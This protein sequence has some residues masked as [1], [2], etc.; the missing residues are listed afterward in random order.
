MG[1]KNAA[2]QFQMMIDDRLEPV[3]DVAD[4]YIDD[5]IVGTRVELGEDLFAAHD[6]DLR[7][8]LQLLK[9]EQLV[10]DIGKCKFFVPEVEFCGHIL[11]NGTRRPAP[12]KLS[13]IEK[14]EVPKVITELRAFLGFTNYY[15]SYVKG[16]ADVVA[17]LQDKLKVPKEEGKKG[18]KKQITWTPTDQEAFEEIK[19]RMCSQ[20][21][22][23][24][25][26]PDKP[27]VLRVDA[28]GYAVGAVLE[29]LVE[30]TRRPT[31]E[32][33]LQKRTVPMA[34]MSQKLAQSQRNWVAR[35]QETY[36]IIL[37]LQKWETW[38]G[39][40]P[41]LVLTDHKALE[42]WAHE[43]L[44][45]PSGPLGRRSRWHQILSKY[46]I[47]VGY[48][49]GKENT[50]ADILSRWAYPASQALRDIS[51]HGSEK[52]DDEMKRIIEDE[53]SAERACTYMLIRD[54]PMD[55]NSWVRGLGKRPGSGGGGPP[56]PAPKRFSFKQP[57][58]RRSSQEA[59]EESSQPVAPPRR[60]AGKGTDR[61]NS[62]GEEESSEI[63]SS[64]E[65][66]E[67]IP[68]SERRG[69]AAQ[70]APDSSQQA[71]SSTQHHDITRPEGAEGSFQLTIPEMELC[72]WEEQY[73]KCPTWGDAWEQIHSNTSEWPKGLQFVQG[74]LVLEDRL[75]LP[76]SLQN[77]H[78]RLY[79]N[80]M[81]HPGPERLWK[82]LV[83]VYEFADFPSVKEFTE[84]VKS[85]CEV[86]QASQRPSHRKGPIVHTPIPSHI[87]DS[88]AIDVFFMPSVQF[89]GEEFDAMVCC[90]DRHSGWI[91]TI[92]CVRKGLTGSK[93]AKAMLKYF[94]RPFGIPRVVTSDQ[95]THFVNAW[96]QTMCA[97]LGIR[98]AFSQAYHH[99][100]NGRA[101]MAGQQLMER[102]RKLN[103]EETI[104]WVEGLPQIL[105]R[106]HDTPGESGFSPYEI[107]FGRERCTGYLPY[108]PPRECPDAKDFFLR[109]EEVDN[110]VA[111]V[112]NDKH[113]AQATKI[114]ANRKSPPDFQVGDQVWYL[115]PEG[116]GTK[117]D[118]RWIGP[119]KVTAKV[120]EHSY[121]VRITPDDIIAAHA[122]FLKPHK[123]DVFRGEGIPLY[124]HQRTVLDSQALTDEWE[125][126]SVL[127]HRVEKDG[128]YFFKVVW[129]GHPDEEASWEPI[130]NFIHRYGT[131]VVR[132][133]KE[134]GLEPPV[135]RFL[136]SEPSQE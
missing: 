106:Y 102:L 119:G 30:G 40:Q 62:D 45:T 5:I 111:V 38:I 17:C 20:L 84:Q 31:P 69:A 59:S 24:R 136:Q 99:Q 110:R 108:A 76:S 41:I 33:V 89:E 51:L 70:P 67:G 12:G 47:T 8:V 63:V 52:D 96:W 23:Q 126:E 78:I 26:D 104:N 34:F 58:G 19:R 25:V 73:R 124:F 61:G 98:Q 107:L 35:E 50:V 4:A 55:R 72:N 43:V 92:P 81:G 80:H 53:K 60:K 13:A 90:V 95:G 122:T 87:M 121:E 82:C 68:L 74:K 86:C 115:R 1:L 118:T 15:S 64:V 130:N 49:P 66:E 134:K 116:S 7:R 14:W 113:A 54:P 103:A 123:P 16:Y 39:L 37:A 97:T 125:V 22:L 88:V 112:L 28:S 105:D 42:H 65:E 135:M 131:D 83:R 93:I 10:A 75:C 79:H 27:F 91:V 29:Q 18:S 109:M 127:D 2:I 100:A 48:V 77:A 44:D 114:N 94:W 120:G 56:P 101:E 11:R 85:E 32:D 46:D 57:Q 3:R 6:K 71:S 133:C 9:D 132:Y 129:K 117:L 21:V 128:K 36:A